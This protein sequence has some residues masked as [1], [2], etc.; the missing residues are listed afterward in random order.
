ML[1][2]IGGMSQHVD[3]ILGY[4]WSWA[5]DGLL[6]CCRASGLHDGPFRGRQP[7]G[8]M[9]PDPHE[10]LQVFPRFS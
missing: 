1:G 5:E 6:G 2:D 9:A 3:A 8:N 10:E 4:L 7:A